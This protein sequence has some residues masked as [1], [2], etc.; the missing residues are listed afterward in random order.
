[1][2]VH[3]ALLAGASGGGGLRG[4]GASTEHDCDKTEE[5]ESDKFVFHCKQFGSQRT[6]GW[7]EFSTR[8]Y[9]EITARRSVMDSAFSRANC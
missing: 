1:V 8:F 3:R 4:C 9:F 2:S 6:G 5:S 7:I